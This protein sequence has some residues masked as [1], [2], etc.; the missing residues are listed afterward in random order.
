MSSNTA[1]YGH[2]KSP[3]T[4]ELLAG[5]SI[6]LQEVAVNVSSRLTLDVMAFS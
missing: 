6:S 5:S 3:L 2:W 4:A 1:P